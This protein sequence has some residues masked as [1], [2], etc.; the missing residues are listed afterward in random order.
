MGDEKVEFV[1]TIRKRVSKFN[2][3][4]F[5]RFEKVRK[6]KTI[7]SLFI[8]SLSVS[9]ISD[10]ESSSAPLVGLL[11][12]PIAQ[13]HA[14]VIKTVFLWK[15]LYGKVHLSFYSFHG[16][17]EPN[18]WSGWIRLLIQ[19][20][21]VGICTYQIDWSYAA[22]LKI[23]PECCTSDFDDLALWRFV[24]FWGIWDVLRLCGNGMIDES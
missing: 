16:I 18:V 2:R 11:T 20:D 19:S 22:R 10:F 4:K 9:F 6:F 14:L 15:S 17:V 12:I 24:R 1:E 21:L 23:R 8:L 5:A 3:W 13:F 7:K